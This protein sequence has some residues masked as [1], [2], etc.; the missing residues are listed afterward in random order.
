LFRPTIYRPFADE[1]PFGWV[2]DGWQDVFMAEPRVWALLLA[3]GELLIAVLLLIR[4]R[5]GYLAVVA[6]TVALALFGWGFLIWCV[7][8]LA[9][10]LLSM[11]REERT[12]R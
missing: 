9:V 2:S 10:V 1:S 8:T 3:A 4:P 5:L 11:V 6:F 7:P 12:K